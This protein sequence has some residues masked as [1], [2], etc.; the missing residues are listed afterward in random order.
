MASPVS[1]SLT[2]RTHLTARLAVGGG[3]S[4]GLLARR[5]S[6]ALPPLLL[7]SLIWIGS[8]TEK[9]LDVMRDMTSGLAK[10]LPYQQQKPAGLAV[11]AVGG[12]SVSLDT[13]PE[14]QKEV[15]DASVP[16]FF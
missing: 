11:E 16:G 13:S 3:G 8:C 4:M 9:D 14:R 2:F 12:I 10:A 7:A 1:W 6:R 5:H 15:A